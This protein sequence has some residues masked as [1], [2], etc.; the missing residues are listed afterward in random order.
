ML[1]VLAEPLCPPIELSTSTASTA[2]ETF[3]LTTTSSPLF[4][5]VIRIWMNYN[6]FADEKITPPHALTVLAK[7]AACTMCSTVYSGLKLVCNAKITQC[8]FSVFLFE[9]K[10]CNNSAKSF[11]SQGDQKVLNFNHQG[12]LDDD[13]IKLFHAIKIPLFTLSNSWFS[14]NAGSSETF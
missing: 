3:D 2:S 14:K 7:S 5:P 4:W 6:Y 11:F 8:E 12:K 9:R 13:F 10:V 1:L